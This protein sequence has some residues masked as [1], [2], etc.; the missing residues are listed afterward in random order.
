MPLRDIKD[1]GKMGGL[2]VCEEV[3]KYYYVVMA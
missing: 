2:G 1:D 3:G